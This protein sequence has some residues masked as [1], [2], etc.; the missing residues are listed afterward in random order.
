M[1][2]P[3]DESQGPSPL[4]GHGSWLMC[5]VAL[6]PSAPYKPD[7]QSAMNVFPKLKLAPN[8]LPGRTI[9]DERGGGGDDDGWMK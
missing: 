7:K 4:H 2:Q 5:E 3:L 1:V 8:R 6:G 9:M